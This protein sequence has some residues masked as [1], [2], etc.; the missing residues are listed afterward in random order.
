MRAD[1]S[2]WTSYY[3]ELSPE[4]AVLE[5]KKYGLQYAE[6][7]DEHGKMLMDRG[8]PEEVG[9]QFR[10]FLEREGFAMPQGHLW[11]VCRI[12]TMPEAVEELKKWLV[13]YDAI[14]V[15]NAILHADNLQDEDITDKERISR[16]VEK[17]RVLGTF[18][19]ERKLG[20]RICLENL[21]NF[22]V[23]VDELLELIEQLDPECFGICLDTGH[24]N[25]TNKGKQREFILKAGKYLKALHIADNEGERD[26]HM[27]PFGK[28]NVEI[29][30][31]VQ[32]LREIDYQGLFNLEI[33]GERLAP[34][35]IRGYK[36][37]Y[38]RKC[39]EYLMRHRG[40]TI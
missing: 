1:L 27:M 28:G 22:C 40:V 7:S 33:P 11:L 29:E 5:L 16:N 34:R 14:G 19:K 10:A 23:N 12:C 31:V 17:L 6:L 9:K 26:Q 32:A 36:I 21:R 8:E 30:S 25:I 24:L 37:E 39:Y 2:V 35:E 38:I 18:I 3:M 13:L 20:I 15:K 4:E